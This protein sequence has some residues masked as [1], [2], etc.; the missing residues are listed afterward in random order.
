MAL[1]PSVAASALLFTAVGPSQQDVPLIDDWAFARSVFSLLSGEGIH[2]IHWASMPQLGQWLWAAPFLWGAGKSHVVLRISTIV[3][4]WLGLG[5]Y[6]ALLRQ[7]GS[8]PWRTALAVSTLATCPLFFL[9]QGTFMTDVPAL[10]FALIALACY[11]RALDTEK[12]MWLLPAAAVATLAAITRQNM[13]IIPIVAAIIA[14]RRPQLRKK[15][16]WLSAVLIPLL[17]GVGVQVWFQGRA[18]T[19]PMSPHLPSLPEA[20]LLCFVMVQFCGLATIPVLLSGI[21][22]I[23]AKFLAIGL[24]IA[25]APAAYCLR[26]G[27]P[28][29]GNHLFPYLGGVVTVYGAYSGATVIGPRPL[30]LDDGPRAC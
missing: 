13:I 18:D 27:G 30:L 23:R 6:Y 9:L 5:A 20:L 17:A 16:T 14:A 24:L 10:S 2:Y 11:G 22:R 1:L 25:V 26:F 7:N 21:G 29:P 4:S 19:K 12:A 28:P 15:W 3:L 8:P